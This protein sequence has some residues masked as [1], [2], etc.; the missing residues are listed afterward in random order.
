MAALTGCATE[1][2]TDRDKAMMAGRYAGLEKRAEEQVPDIHTA[3]T[4]KLTPLCMA[5]SGRPKP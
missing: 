3:K 5:Y 1:M 2:L 4:A